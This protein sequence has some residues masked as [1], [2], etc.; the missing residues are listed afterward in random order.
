MKART[1]L[2][3]LLLAVT[4]SPYAQNLIAVQNGG[5]P[6]FYTNLDS[7]YKYSQNNDTIFLPGGTF[8]LHY[9]ITKRLH[10]IGVG[11]NPDSTKSTNPTYLFNG[12]T[13]ET[14]ADGGSLTGIIFHSCGVQIRSELTNY[15]IS[16]CNIGEIVSV[17]QY[18]YSFPISNFTFSENIISTIYFGGGRNNSIFNNILGGIRN[19]GT[20][21]TIKNNILFGGLDGTIQYSSFENNIFMSSPFALYANIINCIF[22]NDI[23]T[24]DINFPNGTN[25]GFNCIKNQ[26]SSSIFISQSGNS[27]SY[28]EDYHLRPDSPGKNAGKDGT[29]IGIYGGAFPWKEGSIPFNPHFQQVQ[30]APKTDNQGNLNVNIRVKAQD[31]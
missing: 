11:H 14:G 31:H 16:R 18:I 17:A 3:I 13:L 15:Q 27:F 26:S 5:N 24:V 4:G 9:E 23:F 21:N 1:L 2:F 29:D 10:F 6:M 7:A 20:N 22:C 19:I 8:S 30:I 12:L 28:S 25:I